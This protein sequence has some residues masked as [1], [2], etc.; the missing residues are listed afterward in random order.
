MLLF[1]GHDSNTRTCHEKIPNF[2]DTVSRFVEQE[3]GE[4][5]LG[6]RGDRD[7]SIPLHEP[8][9][10]SEV[11]G[12]V[13]TPNGISYRVGRPNPYVDAFIKVKS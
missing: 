7:G 3:E 2:I 5:Y 8:E 1:S 4:S 12:Q 11:R 9:Q 13:T 6:P 10:F